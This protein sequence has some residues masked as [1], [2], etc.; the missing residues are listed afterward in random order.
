MKEEYSDGLTDRQAHEFQLR[1]GKNEIKTN[2]HSALK[3]LLTNFVTS[4]NLLLVVVASVTYAFDDKIS[5]IIIVALI[6]LNGLLGFY[7]E[8]KS[9]KAA[10]QLKRQISA[11]AKVKR[12]GNWTQLPVADLVPGDRVRVEMGDRVPADLVLDLVDEILIDESALTGESYPAKKKPNDPS[13]SNAYMGTI[14]TSGSAEGIVNNTGERTTFGKTSRLL[15]THS[16]PSSFEKGISAMS[17]TLI[18]IILASVLI[19]FLI[20]FFLGKDLVQSLLF[21]VALAVGLIP[22]ALPTIITI[23][24]SSGATALSRY[25]VIVKRLSAI[26]DLGNV[27]ILCTDKT[28]TLTENKIIVSDCISLDGSKNPSILLYADSCKGAAHKNPIDDA[29]DIEAKRQKITSTYRVLSAIK[30]DYQSRKMTVLVEDS[31]SKER[32]IISKGSPE[33]VIASCKM[34]ANVRSAATA[35]YN[36][37]G[38]SGF[39]AI[40]VATK[41]VS[42]TKSTLD[43]SDVSDLDFLGFV[44]FL[45]PPKASVKETLGLARKLGISVKLITG[46]NSEISKH[47]ARETGFVFSPDQIVTGDQLDLMANSSES[48]SGSS[49]TPLRSMIENGIIFS[50]VSPLQKYFIIKKLREYGHS[51]AF[52]GDGVNDA[53]AIKEADVGISVNTATD[54]AKEAADIILLKK[55]LR[56]VVDGISGGRKVFSNVVKY[57]LN[58]LAGNFGDLYTIGAAS[59]FISFIPLTPVQII[60]ANFLSDAPMISISSDNVDDEELVKPKKWD[61]MG[62]V[63]I[64]ALFG[65][66][67]TVF[68]L[69]VIIYFVKLGEGI[70]QTALFLEVLLSEIIVIMSLRSYRSIFKAEPPG[71]MLLASSIATLAIGLLL[72]YLPYGSYFGFEPLS[73]SDLVVLVG[74]V[75]AYLITTEIVKRMYVKA[76]MHVAVMDDDL[77][78]LMKKIPPDLH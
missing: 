57:I 53:P 72:V 7:Q 42:S 43:Q 69:L 71:G 15:D 59:A 31:K 20:N 3:I 63:K 13:E 77:I 56:S 60:L 16:E 45:D 28:G 39:R 27:D 52:L 26:E 58:T 50:R 67:S 65:I 2:S 22:E 68:D 23:T 37:L 30:F 11:L 61:I 44:T 32:I 55:S 66:L 17:Q 14:V 24:L 78:R 75:I 10:E 5:S 18:K 33:A 54:V 34:N 1:F 70:F 46:D 76:F 62:I 49:S 4:L 74:I 73:L 36:E 29:L 64:G 38:A 6:F 25:G 8:Y 9:E 35:K 21:S 48:A 41:K 19:I 47:I 51:V 40:A 12:N